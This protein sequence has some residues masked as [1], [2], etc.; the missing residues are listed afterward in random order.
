MVAPAFPNAPG[1]GTVEAEHVARERI[2]ASDAL[3][4]QRQAVEAF[5]HV[6]HARRQPDRSPRRQADHRNSSM[7]CRR[8][9]GTTS[10]RMHSRAP[11]PNSTSI[12]P[13]R[14]TRLPGAR[15]A[16]MISTS[17]K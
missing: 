9:F 10:P 16:A 1:G 4:L 14:S 11:Q 7:N 3:G 17:T 6:G 13:A 5:A 15:R 8:V 2:L 12:N